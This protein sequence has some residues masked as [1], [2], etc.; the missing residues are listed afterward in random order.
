MTQPS[1]KQV[2]TRD[3]GTRY[4]TWNDGSKYPSVTTILKAYAPKQKAIKKFEQRPGAIEYRDRQ[5]LLGSLVHHRILNNIA[6]RDLEPP[7]FDM[8]LAANYGGLDTDIELCEIMWEQAQEKFDLHPGPTPYVEEPVRHTGYGYAG[9][10]DLLL[11]DEKTM[12]DLKVSPQVYDSYKMQI[13]AYITACSAMPNN[14]NPERG[15]IVC[16]HPHEK[17]NPHLS[18]TAEV[19]EAD[20]LDYWFDKF[21]QVID[22]HNGG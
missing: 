2:N 17:K 19:V 14:P 5:G 15:A 1:L 10:F 11:S 18:P 22:L 12:V 21:T 6:I 4:Y 7:G 8:N 9:R 16:L 3:D 20:N 13:A